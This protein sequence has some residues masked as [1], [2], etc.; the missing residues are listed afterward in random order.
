MQAASVDGLGV[1]RKQS[2][3]EESN[4]PTPREETDA[5]VP[6]VP[7]VV[8][9]CGTRNTRIG[10][11][12]D[13]RPRYTFPSRAGYFSHPPNTQTTGTRDYF[14]GAD[15]WE[16]T[17]WA[18]V[19]SCR[20]HRFKND[21]QALQQPTL[22]LLHSVGN[23]GET[24]LGNILSF[25][26][27]NL[28]GQI[29]VDLCEKLESKAA[30]NGFICRGLAHHGAPNVDVL[31]MIWASSFY[32]RLRIDPSEH[33]VLL[34]CNGG[35]H[36]KSTREK[37]CELMFRQFNVKKVHFCNK[38][39]L[40]LYATGRV[41]GTVLYSGE[42]LS[43]CVPI[44]E[45]NLL[46]HAYTKCYVRTNQGA[47][48]TDRIKRKHQVTT[49]TAR[50]MKEEWCAI[51]PSR[52]LAEDNRVPWDKREG[53]LIRKKEKTTSTVNV[54]KY[55][56]AEL[57]FSEAKVNVSGFHGYLQDDVS[58]SIFKCDLDIRV[59]L[60]ANIVLSGGNT[61][62]TGF[63]ERLK[64]ELVQFVPMYNVNV[65]AVENRD[66][67]GWIGGSILGALPGFNQMQNW[68]KKYT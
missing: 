43:Y 66:E 5:A 35:V 16:S 32:S 28:V 41:T 4:D 20:C 7:T 38:A 22:S 42:S 52:S 49:E 48:V 12:G 68:V 51:Y 47:Y 39:V 13:D 18:F 31:E 46:S 40:S 9:D 15:V 59:E 1:D 21:T 25:A 27:T 64:D 53:H 67:L 61:M 37:Q 57:F 24:V 11:C 3:T 14:T 60:F 50:R 45:G 6:T 63:S 62:I 23:L 54:D 34:C 30:T 58:G 55:D 65:V 33:G 56:Y 26:N 44:Y 19:F 2:N 8:I 17:K 29:C 36:V 10:F